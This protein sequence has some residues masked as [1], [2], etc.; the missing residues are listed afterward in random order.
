[1]SESTTKITSR[2]IPIPFQFLSGPIGPMSYKTQETNP[3]NNGE[4]SKLSQN[5][6]AQTHK[7][8]GNNTCTL[9][10]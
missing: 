7:K 4:L 6:N 10:A 3:V 8:R 2:E 5:S 9:N 1:M